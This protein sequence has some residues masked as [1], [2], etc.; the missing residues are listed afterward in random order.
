MYKF[1]FNAELL[2]SVKLLAYC[3]KSIKFK[4]P[5]T[6]RMK[7]NYLFLLIL[8]S[9]H[10]IFAQQLSG[11]ILDRQNGQPIIYA[12]VYAAGSSSLTSFSGQ[13][14]LQGLHRGDTIKITCVGYRPYKRAY[15]GAD[16]MLIYLQPGS[17]MLRD[18]NVKARH[19]FKLDSINL[20][21]QY[22][23]V[24]GYKDNFGDIFI[25]R[26]P[27]EYVPNNYI[28]APNST[29]DIVSV[30]LL[31]VI[32]LLNKNKAP[33]TK[34]Q[35]TL[36]EDEES[37]YVDRRFS[38]EK[39]TTITN[40]KGDSLQDFMNNYRPTITQVKKMTDYDLIRY[41]KKSYAEFIKTY[42]SGESPFSN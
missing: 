15:T 13:F 19:N 10:R 41:I 28:N 14:S 17:I 26:D 3:I 40:L 38:K 36:L 25:T 39:I 5:I 8:I 11:T 24:F 42:K 37:T 1:D 7:F 31:S 33:V 23:S 9:P 20:R 29:A 6:I 12:S 30:N 22:A 35:R 4:C 21:K 18:V 16:T 32:S 2:S 27:Y 34:L